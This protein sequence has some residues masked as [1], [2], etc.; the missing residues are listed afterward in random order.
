MSTELLNFLSAVQYEIEKKSYSYVCFDIDTG[1]IEKI[2]NAIEE[3]ETLKYIKIL[4]LNIDD[5]F[6]GKKRI[7]DYK[8]VYNLQKDSYELVFLNEE[9]IVP[10]IGDKIYQIPKVNKTQIYSTDLTVRQDIQQKQ[11]HFFVSNS[12]KQTTD[13][14]FF[15]ITAKNDPNILYRNITV[16]TI[17]KD[18]CISFPFLYDIESDPEKLSVYTNKILKKY[19]HEVSQ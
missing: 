11:W 2:T 7:D 16:N 9:I 17:N 15:S 1:K 4:T 5:I 8:I 3:T 10:Y 14:L 18:E 19:A 12:A 6:T 13:R